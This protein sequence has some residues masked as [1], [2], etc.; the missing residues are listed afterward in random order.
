MKTVKVTFRTEH[1][2]SGKTKLVGCKPIIQQV[3][4]HY[5]SG[6][7]GTITGDVWS[8]VLNDNQKESTYVTIKG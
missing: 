5:L 1:D 4:H 8:V 6:K 2:N 7:V 3:K